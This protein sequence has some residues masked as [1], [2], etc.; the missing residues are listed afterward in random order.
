MI[1]EEQ[2][3]GL[4]VWDTA[5]QERFLSIGHAFYKGSDCC[6]ITYDVTQPTTFANINRWK[7]EFDDCIGSK[8]GKKSVPFILLGNKVDQIADRKVSEVKARNWCKQN[9]DVPYFETSAKD[10]T[11]VKDAFLEAGRIAFKNRNETL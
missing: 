4:Q 10:G 6:I 8:D 11:G 9:G 2:I 3:V 5:G 1:I 7:N